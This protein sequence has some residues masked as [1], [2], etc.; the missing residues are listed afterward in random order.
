[1]QAVAD[2]WPSEAWS[3]VVTFDPTASPKYEMEA[4]VRL[5]AAEDA[6]PDVLMPGTWFELYE[7]RRRVAI[8]T[9]L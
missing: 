3:V 1:M 2:R 7:G 4:T 6:P 5:L 9:V 8:G